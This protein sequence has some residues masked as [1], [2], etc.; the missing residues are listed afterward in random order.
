MCRSAELD[1]CDVDFSWRLLGGVLMDY[2]SKAGVSPETTE[3]LLAFRLRNSDYSTITTWRKAGVEIFNLKTGRCESM[4]L[5][6]VDVKRIVDWALGF[7]KKGKQRYRNVTP[8]AAEDVE[9]RSLMC[10]YDALTQTA[11]KVAGES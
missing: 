7:H 6:A 11:D 1:E 10:R 9:F 8:L 4:G 5:P 3:A 2:A